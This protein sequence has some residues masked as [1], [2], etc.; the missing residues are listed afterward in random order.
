MSNLTFL[1]VEDQETRERYQSLVS[2]SA[3]GSIFQDTSWLTLYKTIPGVLGGFQCMVLKGDNVLLSVQVVIYDLPLHLH[4]AY[5]PMG[6][7]FYTTDLPERAHAL[8]FCIDELKKSLQRISTVFMRFEYPYEDHVVLPNL[9]SL[10]IAHTEYRPQHTI[11][12]DLTRSSEEIFA[13]MKQKGRYNIK[14]AERHLVIMEKWEKKEDGWYVD[15]ALSKSTADPVKVFQDLLNE[16]AERDKFSVHGKRYHD[17]FFY[18]LTDSAFLL[19]AKYQG[20]YCAG[21]IFSVSTGGK[22]VYHYGAST[23]ASRHVMAPYK[24][25]W[26]AMLEAKRRGAIEY[27]FLGIAPDENPLHPLHGVTEFKKKFGGR[28]RVYAPSKEYVLQPLWYFLI[29]AIK[30]IRGV[31]RRK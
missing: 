15:G 29:R 28:E 16:T 23:Y 1:R 14:V 21:G 8:Q 27:D 10:R 11:V 30:K 18:S 4:W 9:P 2:Q 12:V 3:Y 25:Q 6:P 26:E 24:V 13:Q 19:L 20:R 31:I 7:I 17:A 5:V 22:A